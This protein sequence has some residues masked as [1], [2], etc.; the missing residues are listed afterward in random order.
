M[1]EACRRSF[2]P[3]PAQIPEKLD[4]EIFLRLAR[5][6]RV[7]G[8][9]WKSLQPERDAVPASIAEAFANDAQAIAVANLR[10]AAGSRALLEAFA[11]ARITLLFVK[12]LTL[13]ALVYGDIGLKSA[14][15]VD[16]L[17]EDGAVA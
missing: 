7:Q 5:F 14:L 8:L 15:D 12:G 13:S 9:V 6:H 4:W 11:E 16:V 17:V 3:D 2:A 10:A 1:V